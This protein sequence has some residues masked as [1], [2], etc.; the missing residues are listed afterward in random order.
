M[1]IVIASQDEARRA[2]EALTIEECKRLKWA[3]RSFSAGVGSLTGGREDNDFVHEAIVAT[4]RGSRPWNKQYSM[5]KHLFGAIRS[6]VSNHAQHLSSQRYQEPILVS[7]LSSKDEESADD[8]LRARTADDFPS[9]FS[10]PE[11][12]LEAKQRGLTVDKI[13]CQ[14]SAVLG[15]GSMGHRV[16]QLQIEGLSGPQ[17]CQELKLTKRQYAVYNMQ[18]VRAVHKTKKRI[19]E[20]AV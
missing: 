17:I 18:V 20:G 7:S 12:E 1:T 6:E 16:F 11:D 2:I 5:Y 13:K 8:E 10:S 15:Q 19:V 4:L 9:T 14:M 3:A